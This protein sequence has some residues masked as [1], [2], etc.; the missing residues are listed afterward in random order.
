LHS[1]SVISRW[2]E[3]EEQ[4]IVDRADIQRGYSSKT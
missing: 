2:W 4:W 3:M 1:K